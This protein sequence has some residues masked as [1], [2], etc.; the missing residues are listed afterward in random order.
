MP[1]TGFDWTSERLLNSTGTPN[2]SPTTA[3]QS[4]PR[5]LS[6][7]ETA[8]IEDDVGPCSA[9]FRG[10]T[11][12]SAPVC[13]DKETLADPAVRIASPL[14]PNDLGWRGFANRPH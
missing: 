12:Q 7:R 4:P 5:T 9:R 3:P 11:L 1:T 14:Q 2:A 8:F 6:S 13:R 10:L